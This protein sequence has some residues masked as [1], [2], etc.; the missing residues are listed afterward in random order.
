M[1]EDLINIQLFF[2]SGKNAMIC[3]ERE[4][5][6]DFLSNMLTNWVDYVSVGEEFGFC[7][8]NVTHFRVIKK[9]KWF[10]K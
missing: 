10:S 3:M 6:E 8:K 9:K 7:G 5:F 4:C 2:V 1:N